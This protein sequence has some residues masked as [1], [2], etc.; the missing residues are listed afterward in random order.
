MPNDFLNSFNGG[1]LGP[2]LDSRADLEK[3]RSS[4]RRI[5]NAVST[6]YGPAFSRGGTEFFG[7]CKF[8]NRPT[9]VI[10]FNYSTTTNFIIEIGHLYFRFWSTNGRVFDPASPSVP[11]EISHPYEDGQIF[12]IKFFQINDVVYFVHPS[13]PVS[14][15]VRVSDDL[16]EFQEEDYGAIGNYPPVMDENLTDTT[17]SMTS[18]M[19]TA[20]AGNTN[21]DVSDV[22]SN[23]GSNYSCKQ[24]VRV[25]ATAWDRRTTYEAGDFVEESGTIYRCI[26]SHSSSNNF[27]DDSDKWEED[28]SNGETFA[29]QLSRGKWQIN[30]LSRDSV[31]ALTASSNL[32]EDGHEGGFFEISHIRGEAFVDLFLTFNGS[33]AGLST[34][35]K[36]SFSTS[37]NWNGIVRIER[38]DDNGVTW[39]TIRSFSSK[40]DSNKLANGQEEDQVLL[41]LSHTSTGLNNSGTFVPRA[42]LEL[43]SGKVSGVVK[44]TEVNSPTSATGIVTIGLHSGSATRRWAEGAWSRKNSFPRA[45]ALH[46]Q[47]LV[48]GGTLSQPLN[49]W[50]SVIGDFGDF[51]ISS[52]DD[53]AFSYALAARQSS[54]IE[55]MESLDR[56]LIGTRGQEFIVRGGGEDDP[57]TP[58]N[59]QVRPQSGRGSHP[60]QA[61]LADDVVLFVQRG[62]QR[63]REFVYSFEKDG[64]VSPNLSLLANHLTRPIIKQMAFQSHPDGILW[65]VTE[66]GDLLAM[67][68]D[69][70]QSVVGWNPQPMSGGDSV[71]SVATT[72]GEDVGTDEVWIVAQRTING[73]V[74]NYIERIDPLAREKQEDEDVDEY[75][76]SDSAIVSINTDK[77]SSV[78]GLGH[79]EGRTVKVLGD[80]GEQL[81]QVVSSGTIDIQRPSRKI[82]VGLELETLIQP[83]KLSAELQDG[84]SR[85]RKQRIHAMRLDFYKTRGAE[86]TDDPDSGKWDFVGF[87]DSSDRMDNPS[88]LFTGETKD[89]HVNSRHRRHLDFAVRHTSPL[90]FC[91]RAII[92]KYE[93]YGD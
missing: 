48:F 14:T 25:T 34:V 72:Y 57:I 78:S 13:H 17:I 43:E 67:T 65:A 19:G 45:I 1:E 22:V 69:R 41:R 3:Y 68:Y 59:V 7:E 88:P 62:G 53:G 11:L 81:D 29:Q 71:I 51:R 39:E 79:L 15:L 73:Q 82:V 92:P 70:E 66:T 89:L 37:G 9:G 12:D 44:I 18:T 90:P 74:K 42:L 87:R 16:W 50:G 55:W 5:S 28:D 33:T 85:G 86:F 20:W 83:M 58:T 35:G 8:N 31:V 23:L 38:S 32:F 54:V 52:L 30:G 27:S 36:W 56:L 47:R 77:V 26:E 6:T 10:G 2:L 84:L 4:G 91:L 21:Y 64:F 80:G 46:E 61:L 63:I 24:D 49:I 40:N 93:S 76:G 75:I 60:V